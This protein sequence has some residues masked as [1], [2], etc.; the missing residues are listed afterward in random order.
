MEHQQIK[1]LK[2]TDWKVFPSYLLNLRIALVGKCEQLPNTDKLSSPCF[3]IESIYQKEDNSITALVEQTDLVNLTVNKRYYIELKYSD[4]IG[5]KEQ[6]EKLKTL[7][8]INYLPHKCDTQDCVFLYEQEFYVLS[9]FSSFCLNWKGLLFDT[10]EHAYHWEKFHQTPSIQIDLRCTLS[11]HDAFIY[12]QKHKDLRDDDFDTRK[13]EVMYEILLAKA[14]QHPYV[15]KKLMETGDR[16]IVEDS[17]RDPVWGWG[18]AQ[19]GQ[20][21]LGRLWMSVREQLRNEI[22]KE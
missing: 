16:I 20:N 12:A 11:A 6:L 7:P 9:N 3:Y 10:S 22:K 18:P 1:Y 17:W 8:K 5:E 21:Q 13:F 2:M 19:D 14:R 4:Y 15:M